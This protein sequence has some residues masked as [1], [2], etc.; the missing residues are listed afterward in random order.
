MCR[1]KQTSFT[2]RQENRIIQQK[3]GQ[4]KMKTPEFNLLEEAWIRVLK[5]DC[6]EEMVSLPEAM[7]HAHEYRDL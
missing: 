3:G 5:D 7:I 2:L 1:I 4:G 6:S